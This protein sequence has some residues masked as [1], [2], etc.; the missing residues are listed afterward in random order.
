[1]I[2]IIVLSNSQF[3]NVPTWYSKN[4]TTKAE[5]LGYND[6]KPDDFHLDGLLD[7]GDGADS[8]N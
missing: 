2:M 7:L 5:I 6:Y 8:P 1:M 4:N 3:I